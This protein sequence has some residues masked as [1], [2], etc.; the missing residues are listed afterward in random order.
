SVEEGK[1][2]LSNPTPEFMKPF[3][4]KLSHPELGDAVVEQVKDDFFMTIGKYRSRLLLSRRPDGKTVLTFT[5]VPL[6]G[7][8]L[9]PL[10]NDPGALELEKEQERYVL[11]K[12]N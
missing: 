7:L 2:R 1:S 5:E 11:K 8:E 12:K 10:V 6:A 3:L 9:A 4:G